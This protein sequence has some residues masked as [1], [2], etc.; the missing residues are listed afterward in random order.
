MMINMR[1]QSYIHNYWRGP[2]NP[3][4]YPSRAEKQGFTLVKRIA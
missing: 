2:P 4:N 1:Q 3:N